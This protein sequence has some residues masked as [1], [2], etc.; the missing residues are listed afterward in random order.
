MTNLFFKIGL[1]CRDISLWTRSLKL[2]QFLTLK[3][4]SSCC[5]EWFLLNFQKKIYS[6]QLLILRHFCIKTLYFNLYRQEW[7]W[8]ESIWCR[9]I[10]IRRWNMK[11]CAEWDQKNMKCEIDAK[12]TKAR[13]FL[14]KYI[15]KGPKIH[16][17]ALKLYTGPPHCTTGASKSGGQGGPLVKFMIFSRT[18]SQL[19]SLIGKYFWVKSHNMVDEAHV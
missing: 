13:N 6:K 5:P 3:Y 2:L 18:V 7:L 16:C 12:R 9:S 10:H 19:C 17:L 15:K 4:V 11:W 1:V 14:K 8:L